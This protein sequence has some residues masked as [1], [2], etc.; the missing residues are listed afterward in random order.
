MANLYSILSAKESDINLTLMAVDSVY[1]PPNVVEFIIAP[2]EPGIVVWRI[3]G[4]FKYM[5]HEKSLD[6]VMI[7]D[8]NSDCENL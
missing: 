4:E 8:D 7:K 6:L 3:N 1:N 2:R 5:A